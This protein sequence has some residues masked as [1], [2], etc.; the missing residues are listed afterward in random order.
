[1]NC[2]KSKCDYC[3]DHKFRMSYYTCLLSAEPMS[4]KKD[5]IV[6]CHVDKRIE[7]VEDNLATLIMLKERLEGLNV[8]SL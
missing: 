5:A 4:F 8:T 6:R 3:V 1:M 2:I 7:E